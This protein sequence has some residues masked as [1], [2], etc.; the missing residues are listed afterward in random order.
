MPEV[1]EHQGQ[2]ADH[3]LSGCHLKEELIIMKC[4][5]CQREISGKKCSQCGAEVPSESRYCMECGTGLEEE[6]EDVIDSDDGVDLED[7]ILCP[8]GTCTGIIIDRKCTECGK[9]FV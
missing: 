3:A 7:R 5:H 2:T 9:P 8:D 1:Q 6:I 4:P